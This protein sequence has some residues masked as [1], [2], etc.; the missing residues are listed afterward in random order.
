[1]HLIG[2]DLRNV[3]EVSYFLEDTTNLINYQK[4]NPLKNMSSSVKVFS[5][6]VVR[7]HLNKRRRNTRIINN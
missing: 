6:K 7:E 2:D 3:F 5:R 1:M 4:H